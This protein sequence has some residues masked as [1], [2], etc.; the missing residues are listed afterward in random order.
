MSEGKSEGKLDWSKTLKWIEEDFPPN[1][2]NIEK[3]WFGSDTKNSPAKQQ[4]T[5]S[6]QQKPQQNSQA[7][8]YTNYPYPIYYSPSFFSPTYPYPPIDYNEYNLRAKK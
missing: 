5:P 4:N 7:V 6:V 8:G 2:K 3:E 1:F